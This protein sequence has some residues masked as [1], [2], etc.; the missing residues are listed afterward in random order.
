M[1]KPDRSAAAARR[2]GPG[3]SARRRIRR[4]LNRLI[5][6]GWRRYCPLCGA[7]LRRLLSHGVIRRDDAVCPVC[8]SRERHR[9]AC[10]Y[11][12]A[13]PTL[14]PP[15]ATVL[16]IA[17]EE[18]VA[19]LLKARRD[20][21]YVSGTRGTH[22]MIDLDAERLPIRSA[23][24]DFLYCSHVLNAV[25]QD[26][27]V[28][29]EFARVLTPRGYAMLQVPVS[30][31]ETLDLA[32]GGPEDRIRAF[33]DA[34]IMRLYGTDVATRLTAAGMKVRVDPFARNLDPDLRIRYGILPE[35]LYLCSAAPA[36]G[37]A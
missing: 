19:R 3:P 26:T 10:L 20:T 30:G 4:G 9:L 16:H 15:E 24:V 35:D 18:E 36:G 14:I 5:Y 25:R 33:G 11:L 28:M 7:H 17:P 34:H 29:S 2:W 8:Q 32:S 23:T 31:A 22:A 13:H 37:G 21:F 12:R 1:T 27:A 6:A